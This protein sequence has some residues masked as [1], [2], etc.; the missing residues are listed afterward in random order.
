MRM[1]NL[2]AVMALL[3][4]LTGCASMGGEQRGE[5]ARI[6]PE[7]IAKLLPSPI[8]TYTLEEIVADAKQGKSADDIIA[9]IKE[10]KSRYELT[11]AQ[12]LDLGK[13][14]VDVAVLDYIQQ[15][16]ALAKQ[17]AVAEE[18]TRRKAERTALQQQ[19]LQER[20]ARQQFY[21]PF[22]WGPSY[23]WRYRSYIPY[24][25]LLVALH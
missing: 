18:M 3:T 4:L 22:F 8:A 17:Q 10:T 25:G 11:S 5:V 21:D 24:R 20:M 19:L 13:Q 7:E 23:H 16:N 6:T 14:G 9:K 15:S 12:V 1:R 2:V